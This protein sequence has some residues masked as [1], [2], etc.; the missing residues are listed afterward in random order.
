M[1]DTLPILYSFRRCPYAIRARLA[2][3]I[4]Q[5]RCQL[6]EV[7]LR[8]KPVEMTAVSPK[9]TVPVLI[10]A[11][12]T[13]IEQSLD[14]MLNALNSNDPEGWLGTGDLQ[15][16]KMLQLIEDTEV[17]FKPHLDRY[18][19]STRYEDSSQEDEREMAGQFLYRLD[20][21][22]SKNAYLSGNKP[23]LDDMAITPFVRQFAQSDRKWFD[24]QPW[25]NLNRWLRKFENSDLFLSVMVKYSAWKPGDP[26]TIFP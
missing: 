22:L 8:D 21:L 23:L 24:E 12:G 2:V 3:S 6:R 17:Q 26:V 7:I 9:G 16:T 11:D 5:T 15:L 19:Y 25:S 14:I 4:S 1:G 20:A 13:V 18:K 10:G